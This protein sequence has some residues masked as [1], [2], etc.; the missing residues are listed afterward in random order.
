[1][2]GAVLAF[3]AALLFLSKNYDGSL[4]PDYLGFVVGALGTLLLANALRLFGS[5]GGRILIVTTLLI[6]LCA[7]FAP[8]DLAFLRS[9]KD[10]Q[11]FLYL[12]SAIADACGLLLVYRAVGGPPDQAL[13]DEEVK[14]ETATVILH[15]VY[16][17]K[18][19]PHSLRNN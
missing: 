3:L 18:N 5:I 10:F 1:M 7:L 14:S 12:V 6:L 9:G 2:T 19:P 11:V 15:R 4:G 8:L 16:D 13:G 17:V